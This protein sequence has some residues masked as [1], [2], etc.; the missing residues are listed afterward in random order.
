MN[1][2]KFFNRNI[3]LTLVLLWGCSSSSVVVEID[4][5]DISA[6]TSGWGENHRNLSVTGKPLS[7]AGTEYAKGLGSHAGSEGHI[8]LDGKKGRFTAS[9][10]VDD[11][12]GAKAS[13][14]FYVFTNKG[15]AF[16][17]GVMK[18]GDATKPIDINLKGITDLYLVVDPTTDGNRDDHA[19]WV[20]AVF[21]VQTVPVAVK[22]TAEE[23]RYI[24][25]PPPAPEPRINGAKIT[26]A[27]PD[28]PF[29]FTIATTGT[30]PMTFTAE[31]LPEG[32]SLNGET[33]VITGSCSR[34]GSYMVPLTAS[35]STGTCHDT[36]EIVIGGG[37]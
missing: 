17:S 11:A 4:E 27:S 20:N 30:R 32:L 15:T 6:F 34:T 24:L 7:V 21:T 37:L 19:D 29:L 22:D 14:V 33:G 3:F 10:G 36:L 9:V 28:K 25:T 2:N 31:N 1:K 18:K 5:L 23:Q 13:V 26:G 12:A 16:N 35:N 8:R